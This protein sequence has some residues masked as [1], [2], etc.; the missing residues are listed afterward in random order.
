MSQVASKSEQ[1]DDLQRASERVRD[2]S[3]PQIRTGSKRAC[4]APSHGYRSPSTR[5]ASIAGTAPSRR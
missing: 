2:P 4:K 3:F 1:N 5:I